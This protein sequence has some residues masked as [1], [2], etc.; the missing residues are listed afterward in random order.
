MSTLR[1]GHARGQS[2]TE[3][4]LI[5]VCI[6]VVVILILRALGINVLGGFGNVH[7]GLAQNVCSTC[8]STSPSCTHHCSNVA[9]CTTFCQGINNTSC[10]VNC[11]GTNNTACTSNCTGTNNTACHVN[12]HGSNNPVCTSGCSAAVPRD[13]PGRAVAVR[14]R[15]DP[16]AAS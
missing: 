14:P 16:A 12:C 10:T 7:N 2:M 8:T 9:G 6:A 4:A 13:R 5:L 1:R 3:Y 15:P 11:W